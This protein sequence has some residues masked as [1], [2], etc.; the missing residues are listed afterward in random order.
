VAANRFEDCFF[1]CCT[2]SSVPSGLLLNAPGEN[3]NVLLS[4]K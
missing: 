4:E 2:N 3:E 1:H